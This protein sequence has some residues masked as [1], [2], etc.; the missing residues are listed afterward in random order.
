M[1]TRTE[2]AAYI[3]N[4]DFIVDQGDTIGYVYSIV[5]DTSDYIVFDMVDDDGEHFTYRAAPFGEVQIVESFE[6]E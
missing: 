1:K 5:E 3:E 4:N 6:D 2:Y